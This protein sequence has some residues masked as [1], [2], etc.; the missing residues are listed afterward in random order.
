M[1]SRI[2]L[3]LC[4]LLLVSTNAYCYDHIDLVKD[5]PPSS[6]GSQPS[7]S[8]QLDV[9]ASKDSDYLI[10]DFSND[11]MFQICVISITTNQC[12]IEY[13]NHFPDNKA[14]ISISSLQ[15]DSY[16]LR[17]CIT[18]SWWIGYFEVD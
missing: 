9:T 11:V 6:Q 8:N 5:V 1:K 18:D 17:I 12:V 14:E 3:L 10:V 2:N 7:R 16:M 4:L 13:A 15:S